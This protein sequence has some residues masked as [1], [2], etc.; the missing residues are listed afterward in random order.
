ME[1]GIRSTYLGPEA[2][3]L[4]VMKQFDIQKGY[5]ISRDPVS[6]SPDPPGERYYQQSEIIDQEV[7]IG[8]MLLANSLRPC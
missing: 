2:Q 6:I 5:N 8:T 4:S 7:N 3:F 1:R